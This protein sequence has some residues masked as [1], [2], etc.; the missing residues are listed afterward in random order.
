MLKRGFD[1]VSSLTGIILLFPFMLILWICIQLE[2]SGGGLYSQVR[3]GKNGIDFRLWKFRTMQT[4]AD[5]K[6][7]LTIGGRDSRVTRIG[8]YLRKY[9]LDEL[10]QLINVLVGDM[11]IVGPRPEVRK[12]VE[13]YS[14]D[15]RKV[16]S[17]KPGITDYAS[18]EYSNE[19][20]LLAKSE[21]PEKTYIE[22]V[23]PAKL[24]LN[25]KYLIE[26][27]FFTD[28][29]IILHTIGKIASK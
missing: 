14:Q 10:P 29:K 7:L 1:V 27:G 6:G 21:N 24:E 16:L 28:L 12:Y 11:S 3:V 23:L 22:E 4:G 18:I 17:V 8:Y 9:K 13:L 25:Q 26:Q 19:N 20:E 2:S 5:K 15:Q